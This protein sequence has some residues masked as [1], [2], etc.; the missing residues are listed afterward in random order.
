ML[1]GMQL[2]FGQPLAWRKVL[3]DIITYFKEIQVC[4]SIV[5]GIESRTVIDMGAD[6][7]RAAIKGPLET[8]QRP[9]QRSH[10]AGISAIRRT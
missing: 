9:E 2:T 3:K 10:A 5:T 4:I 6:F 1:R 8:R 7:L